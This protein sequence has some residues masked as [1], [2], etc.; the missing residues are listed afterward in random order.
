MLHLNAGV[1]LH[2]VEVF[3]GVIDE[4]LDRAAV[5]VADLLAEL[6]RGVAHALAHLSEIFGEGHSSMI[7]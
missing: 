4:E 7:F 3:A 2:E 1:H 6:H 5:L